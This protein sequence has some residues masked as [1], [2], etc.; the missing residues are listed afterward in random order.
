M[1][2]RDKIHNLMTTLAGYEPYQELD[3]E[4]RYECPICHHEKV[5]FYISTKTGLWVC[6][7]CGHKGN[8]T[9]LVMELLHLSFQ[10]A[11]EYLKDNF[12]FDNEEDLPD[13]VLQQ[14][15]LF[16]QLVTL[17]HTYNPVVNIEEPKRMPQLPTNAEPLLANM[18]NPKAFPYFA[19]LNSR[20]VTLDQIKQANIHYVE[21]GEF[22]GKHNKINTMSKSVVFISSL[23]GEPIF[24]NSR[25]IDKDAYI[26][27][28]NAPAQ[29]GEFSRRES[30]YG[31]DHVAGKNVVLC[32]GIFNAFTVSNGQFAGI[33]TYGKQVTDDQIQ[34]ILSFK[35]QFRNLYLFLDNDARK[36]ELKLGHRLQEA[37][38]PSSRLF[39]V[40]NP[41][42][43]KDA[44]DLGKDKA[45]DLV[46][47]SKMFYFN[48]SILT[49]LLKV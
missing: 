7:N 11:K 13:Q 16:D 27:S 25:S 9:M 34:L 19:Y 5:K 46:K 39:L 17:K 12:S 42:G 22:T 37:G 1:L 2:M 10:D 38:F 23:N 20:G 30:V 6:Y 4:F 43:D 41:F 3:Y 32:E 33:A 14:D 49:N 44:N 29:V 26:K 35:D 47:Q 15:S 8:P 21:D 28:F 18:D 40:D 31:L 24:W 48:P 36:E 45:I